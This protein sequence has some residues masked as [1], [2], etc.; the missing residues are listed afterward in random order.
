MPCSILMKSYFA[1]PKEAFD[2]MSYLTAE[3]V[4]TDLKKKVMFPVEE[5]KM[6]L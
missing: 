5:V 6:C 4:C 3:I 1:T 2:A